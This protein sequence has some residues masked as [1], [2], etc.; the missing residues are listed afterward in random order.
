MLLTQ[1]TSCYP[2][3]SMHTAVASFTANI[4]SRCWLCFPVALIITPLRLPVVVELYPCTKRAVYLCH[5]SSCGGRRALVLSEAAAAAPQA[6]CL[7]A[8]LLF[9]RNKAGA[10]TAPALLLLSKQRNKVLVGAA[11]LLCRHSL[12]RESGGRPCLLRDGRAA[13]AEE[14]RARRCSPPV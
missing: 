1:S 8:F 13:K 11:F 2:G 9:L 4:S 14:V 7:A 3:S 12:P 6:G 5:P 10:D